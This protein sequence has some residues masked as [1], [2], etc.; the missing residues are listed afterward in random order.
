MTTIL[1]LPDMRWLLKIT[2]TNAATWR[3][4]VHRGLSVAA[5]GA[6]G[7]ILETRPLLL[8]AVAVRLRDDL[9]EVVPRKLAANIVRG[10]FDRWAEGVAHAEHDGQDVVFVVA[11]PDPRRYGK[12]ANWY[13]AVGPAE[14]LGA[15]VASLPQPLRR[16][17]VIHMRETLA[18]IRRGAANVRLDLS[19][20]HFFVPPD[21]PMLTEVKTEWA[22]WRAENNVTGTRARFP[23][24]DKQRRHAIEEVLQ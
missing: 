24:V 4:D 22:K 1:A 16:V 15:Y 7:P 19:G 23:K 5:F 13:C 10:F 17:L 8:D 9:A 2:G 6:S 18:D 21:H 12:D 14:K 11:E 20:A 3:S